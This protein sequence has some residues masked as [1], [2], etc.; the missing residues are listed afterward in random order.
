MAPFAPSSDLID[1]FTPEH[2][3]F[4][5]RFDRS[6]FL[7]N[8]IALKLAGITD[9]TVSPGGGE[10]VKDANGRLTGILRGSAAE[11]VRKV[12][13]PVPFEQRLVQVRAVLGEAREG[14]VTTMQD[15]TTAEPTRKDRRG[16][17]LKKT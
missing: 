14:G 1:P 9:S 13:P 12:M 16:R 17:R 7:A 3:V 2:P 10:I 4:V 5:N 8:S 15:L 6:M 11:M